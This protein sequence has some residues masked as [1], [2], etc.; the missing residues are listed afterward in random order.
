MPD[1]TPRAKSAES[2]ETATGH[3][4]ETY[5]RLTSRTD[6]DVLRKLQRYWENATYLLSLQLFF[7][8]LAFFI[9]AIFWAIQ[10]QRASLT[11]TLI[12]TFCLSNLTVVLKKAFNLLYTGRKPLQYWAAYVGLL[13]L[14]TPVMVASATAVAFWLLR[15]PHDSFADWLI[16]GWKFPCVATV[17]FGI[18]A[19]AYHAVT[20]RLE[21]RNQALQQKVES[22]AAQLDFQEQELKRAREIQQAL[23]P[24]E[25]PQLAG[26]EIAGTW[27]P[28]R[29]VGGDYFDV[30]RLSDTKVGIC[31]AD[32]VGKSVSGA[33]LMA[34][35]QAIVRAFASESVSP[36]W[37]CERLNA[38]LCGNIAPEKFVTLFYGVLDGP[39]KTLQYA[40]AGHPPP[41]LF[42]PS[43]KVRQLES[44]G[45]VLGVFPT[46]HYENSIVQLGLQDRL[47]LFTDGLTEAAG[48]DGEQLGEEGLAR[49]LRAL[50]DQPLSQFNASLLAD[51]K[52]FS[53]SQLQ[54]DATL[55]SIAVQP[56]L[57]AAPVEA[58]A[59]SASRAA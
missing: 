54:D 33:L 10:P 58:R 53:G 45:A 49:L 31:I 32:V 23:L 25:I 12:Y 29:I 13:L 22:D 5:E 18:G 46:W 11:A 9:Y 24:K 39:R 35:V 4:S 6:S 37:L 36:A 40:S 17:A 50:P 28:A 59:K 26:F 19:Q 34:N 57:A 27:E 44:G 15:A 52:Q 2:L 41:L 14:C 43:G 47:L 21:E 56:Q 55:I 51:V 1:S 8:T 38:T 42:S 16:H 7:L 48:S 20:C 3:G 30:I